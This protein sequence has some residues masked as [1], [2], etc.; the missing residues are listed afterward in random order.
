MTTCQSPFVVLA[1]IGLPG[2]G[3]STLARALSQDAGLAVIDRD[4]IRAGM[5]PPYVMG[6]QEKPA[7]T[8][9]LWLAVR[10]M[11]ESGQGVIIDGMTFAHR[12]DRNTARGLAHAFGA[13]WMPV[14][15]RVSVREAMARIRAQGVHPSKE[16]TPR[17][18]R[19]VASRFA[20]VDAE[21]LVVDGRL[22]LAE[23]RAQVEALMREIA[24]AGARSSEGSDG[25][26]AAE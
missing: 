3:K 4:A 8:A 7:A 13:A 26:A 16:R 25:S 19:Q 22:P 17:L 10:A 2:C 11:L 15:V 6:V 5:F 23:Q 24:P 9:A 20:P 18:V 21:T 12:A 14:E 1:L